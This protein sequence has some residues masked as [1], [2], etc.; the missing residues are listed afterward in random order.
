MPKGL[1]ELATIAIMKESRRI[2]RQSDVRVEMKVIFQGRKRE[3]AGMSNH[4][5]SFSGMK[6]DWNSLDLLTRCSKNTYFNQC[7]YSLDI[8]T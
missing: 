8:N 6:I 4:A 7:Y 2:R 3:E 1:R 5:R